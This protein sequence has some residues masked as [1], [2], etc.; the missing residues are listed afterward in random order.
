MAITTRTV[1]DVCREAKRASREL[2]RL[3]T[4]TRN[5]AL[6]AIAAA[7]EA[8]RAEVL[9]AN[10]RDMEAGRAGGLDA[11]L[12]DRLALDDAR[13]AGIAADVR[14]IVALP[15]PVG[16]TI[17]GFR[18]PN[19]LDV[20]R[21][22]TPLGVVAVVYEARPNVTIDA[23]ALALKSGNAI[24]LRGS[25]SAAHSN[26][27]LAAVAAEAA[28]AAGLPEGALSLVAGGGR[29]EL[30]ELAAQT[31]VVGLLIPRGGEGLKGALKNVATVPVMYAASGNCHVYVDADADLDMAEAIIL[32]AKLQRPGVC[33]AAETL[34]VHRDA[35]AQ[36]LPRA[37]SAL[38]EA[39]VELRV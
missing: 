18:L 14:T 10:E 30:S 4:D 34:L 24:V 2:A 13:V 12:L 29:E 27:V 32:N 22:R 19:G 37:L 7:L 6:E 9:E 17:E 3:D 5:G 36:F 16:E 11:A 1:T 15:D 33:N 23:T 25:S 28:T 38:R 20:R 21:V 31:G 26:A 8:R 39:G 35:A